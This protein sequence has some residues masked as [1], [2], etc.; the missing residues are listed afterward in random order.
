MFLVCMVLSILSRIGPRRNSLVR[1]ANQPGVSP[2]GASGYPG[3]H[4]SLRRIPTTLPTIWKL[5]SPFFTWMGG[6]AGFSG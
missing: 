5:F 6:I 4:H 2:T 1:G 3:H